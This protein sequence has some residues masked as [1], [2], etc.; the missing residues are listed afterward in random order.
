MLGGAVE[1]G[2]NVGFSRVGIENPVAEW[3]IY[4][5]PRA[6]NLVFGSGAPV[7]L[8][9]LNATRHAP[10]TPRFHRCARDHRRTPEGRFAYEMLS[11]NYEFVT[12]GGFQFWDSLTAVIATERSLASFETIPLTVV[13]TEGPASGLTRPDP[14]GHPVQVAMA[15]DG[16]RFEDLFLSVLNLDTSAR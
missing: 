8:V 5:D 14:D 13:E 3:D 7:T 6:A 12:S 2:G 15:A 10:V 9:P 16:E 4:I 11:A 1:L